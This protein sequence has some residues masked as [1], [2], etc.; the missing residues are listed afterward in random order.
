M[1]IA[2]VALGKM[3]LPV[4]AWYASRGHD[5]TGCDINATLVAAVNRG[6]CPLPYEPGL[7][8]ML[9]AAVAAGRLRATR[10]TVA[11]VGEADVVLVLVPLGVDARHQPDYGPLDTAFAAVGRGLRPGALVVLET[12]VAVGDTRRRFLPIL[13][14]ARPGG[15]RDFHLAFSPERVQAGSVFRDL[16]A[17]PRIV[18][19]IDAE[20][21]RRAAAFY[22]ENFGVEVR[23]LSSSEAAEFCKLAESV[24]R[25]VN[26]ALANELALYAETCGVDVREVFPAANSQPQ[27]HLHHPGVGVGGHCIPVYPYLLIQRTP[28]SELAALARRINDAMPAHAVA[29]LDRHLGGLAGRRVL[30]LGVSFRAGVREAAHSPALTLARELAARGARPLAHD[31]LFAPEELRALGLEPAALAPPPAVDAVVLQTAEPLYRTLDFRGFPGLRVVLDGRGAL[32]PQVVAAAGVRYLAIGR[33]ERVDTGAA[34]S[35]GASS[36][37]APLLEAGEP[38]MRAGVREGS[39]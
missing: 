18:G 5:V 15:R 16:C 36:S 32:D 29:L 21:G 11:G 19:G 30:I 7:A 28:F 9:R 27:S 10:D 3:G 13:L 37:L 31:P 20:S 17:Y 6:E 33:G 35:D 38:E 26:I 22:A 39:R 1:K 25:D 12:T 4:A 24:Y 23:L 8:D 2:V 14:A 34:A